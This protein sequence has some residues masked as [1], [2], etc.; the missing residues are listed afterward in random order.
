MNCT[1]VIFYHAEITP[2]KLAIIAHGAVCPYGRLAHGIVS[3]QRRLAAAGVTAGQ[4]AGLNIAHPIDHFIVACALYRLKVASAS[5]NI[6]PD[7]YLDH[8]PFDVV[9][10]DTMNPAVSRK[11][12]TAKIFLVDTSWFKD[13]VTFSVAERSSAARDPDPDWTCR[14]NC[15][16]NDPRLPRVVKTTSRMLEAQIV[17]YGVSAFSDWERMIS[18][19]PLQS[20]AGLLLGLTALWLGRTVLFADPASVRAFDG[21]TLLLAPLVFAVNESLFP[22]RRFEYKD[23]TAVAPLAETSNVLV[24]HPSLNVTS[25]QELIELAKAKPGDILYATAGKG[26]AT[27]LAGELFGLMAEVKMTPVHY[28]GGGELVKD[29]L[30]GE[31]KVTFST[32]PPVLDFVQHKTL[33]GIATTAIHRDKVLPDL[34]T[35]AESGLPGYDVRL[36]LG[37][38]A[39]AGT[40]RDAVNRL[41]SATAAALESNEVKTVLAAQ[42]FDPLAGTPDSFDAF[43][44]AEIVKWTKVIKLSGTGASG[45]G[46]RRTLQT[47]RAPTAHGFHAR[48]LSPQHPNVL[49]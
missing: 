21:N 14:V 45:T 18:V 37:L 3:T 10:T 17:T 6:A 12:P 2:E 26:T 41:A 46:P 1:D 9:L 42:G 7:A 48:S 24:V 28:R 43:M 29:L 16:P 22:N 36:W 38:L 40:P 49:E 8:V 4:T 11:Q 39:P 25:V 13:K 35:I 44:R 20:P 27:H 34:P 47:R 19:A 31:V 32:I 15:F 30:S 5:I 23:F 33:R